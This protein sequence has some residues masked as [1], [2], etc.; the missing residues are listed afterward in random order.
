MN[1][2]NEQKDTFSLILFQQTIELMCFEVVLAIS[3]KSTIH[4]MGSYSSFN[5]YFLSVI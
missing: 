1:D 3:L 4:I 2:S 5:I